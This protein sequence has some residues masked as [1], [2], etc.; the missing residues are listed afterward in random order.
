MNS[1]LIDSIFDRPIFLNNFSL[2]FHRITQSFQLPHWFALLSPTNIGHKCYTRS[3]S[4]PTI[5]YSQIHAFAFQ[6][7][8]ITSTET[9]PNLCSLF[10]MHQSVILSND[11]FNY[12]LKNLN[13]YCPLIW[14]FITLIQPLIICSH[15]TVF[16]L[17]HVD[18]LDEIIK[19]SSKKSAP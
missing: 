9:I 7:L 3:S 6:L 5:P 18:S 13:S 10:L 1:T 19:F 15:W 2:S 11:N 12:S 4:L 16:P 8:H 14:M 17:S